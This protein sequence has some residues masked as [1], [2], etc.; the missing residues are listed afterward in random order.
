MGGVA[1]PPEVSPTLRAGGN[2]TGGHRPPGTDVDTCES[3][4]PEVADTVR[5]HPRPGSNSVGQVVVDKDAPEVANPLTARMAKGINTTLDEGQTPVVCFDTTQV[6]HPENRSKPEPG[7][8]SHPLSAK[9][10]PP[11]IEF[12]GSQDPDVSGDVTHPV[13]RN[14]GPETCVAAGAAVRRLTPRECERLQGFPDDWTQISWRGKEPEDCPDG[15]RYRAM[16]NS[17]AVNVM[18][19][20]GQRIEL[21]DRIEEDRP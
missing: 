4:V 15:H 20:I 11:A 18:R 19:W 17:M 16:G 7:R 1:S 21:A 3:L 2:Q 12:H 8:P 14:R 13:G 5:S 6:T 9:G 10:H